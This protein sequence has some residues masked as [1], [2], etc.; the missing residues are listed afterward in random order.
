MKRYVLLAALAVPG[1]AQ[2]TPVLFPTHDV[3]VT[4]A[5]AVPGQ[6]AIQAVLSYQADTGQARVDS[7]YGYYVLADLQNGTA[8]LVVPALHALVQAPD[9]SLLAGELH[10]AGGAR[11][12]PVGARH[13]AGLG[14]EAY[15]VNDHDGHAEVCLTPDG[16]VL[17]FKGENARGTA[18]VTAQSVSAGAVG[19]DIFVQ[20]VGY[21]P[22]SLPAGALQALL[23][24]QP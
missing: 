10:N 14:C 11:F 13:Y 15:A 20:P 16:V 19:D 3:T 2:A 6:A 22:L 1:L 18:E 5:V 8:A 17:R 23:V 4:Y 21:T 7:P 24:P 12:T 9:F